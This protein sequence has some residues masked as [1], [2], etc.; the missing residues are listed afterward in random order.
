[1][2]ISCHMTEIFL[3]ALLIFILCIQVFRLH[4]FSMYMPGALGDQER[5]LDPLKLDL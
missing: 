1:M 4:V 5:A 3:K 2:F